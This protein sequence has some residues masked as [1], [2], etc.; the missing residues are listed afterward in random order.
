MKILSVPNSHDRTFIIEA[1]FPVKMS[2]HKVCTKD[3]MCIHV[4]IFFMFKYFFINIVDLAIQ[5]DWSLY[6][7][8]NIEEVDGAYWFRVVHACIRVSICHLF[9]V[10]H[11]L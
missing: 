4:Q 10:C 8:P 2:E 5:S 6:Y 1:L 11:T 7:A 3:T 9:D